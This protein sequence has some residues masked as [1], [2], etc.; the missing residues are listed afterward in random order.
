[1]D[2][3]DKP[4]H[5]GGQHFR[6]LVLT[7]RA[8]RS[9]EGLERGRPRQSCAAAGRANPRAQRR[10]STRRLLVRARRRQRQ[11]GRAARRDACRPPLGQEGISGRLAGPGAEL[12]RSDRRSPA[13]TRRGACAACAPRRAGRSTRTSSQRS[14][15]PTAPP[16]V[17]AVCVYPDDGRARRRGARRLR[18]PGRLGR[19]RLSRR[20][21]AAR[22]SGST[23]SDYALSE[24]AGEIDIVIT[25]AHVLNREW[26]RAL[27]RSQGD[28]RSLRRGAS[29]DDPRHRR[30][31]DAAQRLLGQHGRDAGRRRLHQ[32]LHRQGRR[33]RHAAGQP[34]DGCAR[35]ATIA[36]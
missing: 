33:Q 26:T 35:C 10:R 13:T 1:M 29:Q 2:G 30:P 32:D 4:G 3:R 36:T 8:A 9:G 12:P 25:R 16:T 6:Q 17:A 31:E 22:S 20:P 18:H 11:R 34:G 28:A 14:V 23:R 21:D 7:Y 15:S 24:G 27:R 5:D 19:R